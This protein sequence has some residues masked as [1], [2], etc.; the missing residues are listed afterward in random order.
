SLTLLSALPMH[1]NLVSAA[2]AE[3]AKK[4]AKPLERISLAGVH[5]GGEVWTLIKREG[6]VWEYTLQLSNG[7][8]KNSKKLAN[9]PFGGGLRD[10][11]PSLGQ[12]G[13]PPLDFSRL[14]GS[15]IKEASMV[16]GGQRDSMHLV[17]TLP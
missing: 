9:S 6:S 12:H 16:I 15:F 8:L 7:K 4:A 10:E 1:A 13:K 11:I 3:M 14:N 5:V 2:P 17:L